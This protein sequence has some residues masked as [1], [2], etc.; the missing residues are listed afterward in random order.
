MLA[1]RRYQLEDFCNHL[2]NGKS[3]SLDDVGI[4]GGP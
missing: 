3:V 1:P 4:G 2:L